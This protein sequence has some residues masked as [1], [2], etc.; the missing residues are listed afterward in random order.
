MKKVNFKGD[1]MLTSFGTSFEK[2]MVLGEMKKES[3]DM[4][5]S[6][7]LGIGASGHL[8]SLFVEDE[9]TGEILE[10]NHVESAFLMV[11]DKRKRSSGW[12]AVVVGEVSKISRVLGFLSKLTLDN[13]KKMTKKS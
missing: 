11:E 8:I 7:N 3:Q 10:I 9:V 12:L 1:R 2:K 6:G 13:L 5:I 4:A